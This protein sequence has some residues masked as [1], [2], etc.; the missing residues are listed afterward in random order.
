VPETTVP[1]P[2]VPDT[3]VPVTPQEDGPPPSTVPTFPSLVATPAVPVEFGGGVTTATV[4]LSLVDGSPTAVI[5]ITAT[6]D[7]PQANAF[8]ITAD[9]CA[10]QLLAAPTSCEVQVQFTPTTS[11][12]HSARVVF[13]PSVGGATTVPLHATTVP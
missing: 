11:G 13:I 1:E 7:G 3:T 9:T 6:L 12:D 10:Y 8:E 4:S 5:T 2:P